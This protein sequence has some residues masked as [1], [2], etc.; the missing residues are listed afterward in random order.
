MKKTLE[1]TDVISWLTI[2]RAKAERSQEVMAKRLKQDDL[3]EEDRSE[4]ENHKIL[5]EGIGVAADWMLD[6]I[7]DLKHGGHLH[8]QIAERT[9]HCDVEAENA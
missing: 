7:I 4:Y 1:L 5:Y 8:E 6:D 2:Y 3:S 9:L